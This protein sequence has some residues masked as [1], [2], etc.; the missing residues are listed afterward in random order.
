[1]QETGSGKEKERKPYD[2]L[3]MAI[4][5]RQDVAFT[6]RDE[7]DPKE[8]ANMKKFLGIMGSPRKHGNTHAMVESVLAGAKA[9]GATTEIVF[10]GDLTIKECNGCHV[11]W[12]GKACTKNDDMQKLYAKIMDS[13]VIVFG[14]P[15]YWYGTTALM[16]A[17]IDRFVY[18]NCELNRG[19][20]RNKN[21]VV[22]VPFEEE[23]LAT[24]DL[25]LELF[26]KSLEFLEM[27]FVGHLLAP[28]VKRREEVAENLKLMKQ[29]LEMGERLATLP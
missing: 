13:D 5:E 14:T 10:L 11:C 2:V 15:V 17:F 28:G 23:D 12:T 7:W 1:M 4:D 26:R 21:A 18:F 27:N 24:A 22:V 9:H 19:G 8:S 3:H 20:V 16:K 6:H 25:V 29:G